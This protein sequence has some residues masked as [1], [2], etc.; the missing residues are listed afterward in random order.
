MSS[1]PSAGIFVPTYKATTGNVGQS[2]CLAVTKSHVQMLS[3]ARLVTGKQRCH[4]AVACVQTRCQIR[5]G[6]ADFH[7][8]P[9]PGASN[10]HQ[11]EFSLDHDIV[12]CSLRVRAVLSISGDGSIDETR[13]DLVYGVKVQL[14]L[15]QRPRNVILNKNVTFLGES[16]QNIDTRGILEGQSQGLLV[17][18]H[19]VPVGI[20]SC[21]PSSHCSDLS[22]AHT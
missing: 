6:H 20:S 5:H 15:L 18:V 14:V 16:V 22:S 7:W 1:A 9:V 21:G 4:D 13:I 10:V 12:A 19:L 8:R 11:S 17:A 2:S 3:P